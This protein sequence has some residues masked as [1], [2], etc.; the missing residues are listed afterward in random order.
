MA[1]D[2]RAARPPAGAG[3][4]R[5]RVCHIGKKKEPEPRRRLSAGMGAGIGSAW[6]RGTGLT[7]GS[8]HSACSLEGGSPQG[9]MAEFAFRIALPFMTG[10]AKSSKLGIN[11]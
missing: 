9:G 10:V 4:V 5:F 7:R 2:R 11:F 3:N 1:G 6:R 8:G